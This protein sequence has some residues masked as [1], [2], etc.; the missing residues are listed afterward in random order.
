MESKASVDF[1]VAIPTYNGSDRLPKVLDQLRSQ[2]NAGSFSWEVLVIDNNSTDSTS[3][4][5]K[6]YQVEWSGDSFLRY[7]FEAKQG[8]AFAR[9][10]AIKEAKGAF[11]GF[12]D[13]DNLPDF[14]WVR[15]AFV[16]GNTHPKAGAYGGQIHASYETQPP[17]NFK[18]IQSFLAIR[19]QGTAPKLYQ[20]NV[21]SLP[22]GAALV[23]RREAWCSSVPAHPGLVGR[24]GDSMLAGEDYESLL[25]IHRAGWEIWYCPT[26]HTF[27]Q[28]PSYRLEK[29]YLISLARGAGLCISKLRMINT[30]NWQKPIVL[31]R[32]FLGNL[33]RLILHLSR[34]KSQ[35]KTDSI[36]ACEMEFFRSSM[37][38]P[39]Y[40]LF[41]QTEQIRRSLLKSKQNF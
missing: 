8:L 40:Y 28:I 11:V 12:L 4:L 22:P 29:D 23:I 38:S 10:R 25:Y 36:A 33:R 39:F 1:T 6:G 20:P 27:H 19:E 7:C 2:L 5:V 16:F 9:Q 18:R 17:E 3:E 31:I 35:V 21:L 37:I 15:A 34:Y 26:M 14:N 13:D 24:T 30:H 41:M 32:V